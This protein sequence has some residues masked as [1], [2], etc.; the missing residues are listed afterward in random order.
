MHNRADEIIKIDGGDG[1][2]VELVKQWLLDHGNGDPVGGALVYTGTGHQIEQGYGGR[3]N[4]VTSDDGGGHAL[5]I[6]GWDDAVGGDGAW[7]MV[8]NWSDGLRWVK[9]S[10]AQNGNLITGVRVKDHNPVLTFKTTITC[11]NRNGIKIET[12]VANGND[13][14]EPEYINGY[15]SAF[16]YS[17]QNYPMQGDAQSSTIEI[18]LDLTDLL[19]HVT[20]DEATF[21]L[22]IS[23]NGASGE[24]NSLTLMDYSS[25]SVTEIDGEGASFGGNGV[26]CKVPI[27]GSNIAQ[28]NRGVRSADALL[29]SHNPASKNV[30]FSFPAATSASLNIRDIAGRVVYSGDIGK[31]NTSGEKTSATWNMTGNNGKKI[32]SG[33]Y[34]ATVGI[35]NL[36]GNMQAFSTKLNVVD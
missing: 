3:E 23:S 34:I 7:L 15:G 17:G 6:A 11:G 19:E 21:F 2:Y 13:A 10:A 28:R 27:I 14:S 35:R 20:G 29:V 30:R 36:K 8:N 22:K 9:Y 5:A 25:G 26:L 16:N 32:M 1:G 12:G 4:P 33:V 18:G 24:V 31:L